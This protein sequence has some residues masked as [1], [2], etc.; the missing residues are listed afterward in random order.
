MRGQNHDIAST[1]LSVRSVWLASVLWKLHFSVPVYSSCAH[2][3]VGSILSGVQIVTGHYEITREHPGRP[4]PTC[5]QRRWTGAHLRCA[6]IDLTDCWLSALSLLASYQDTTRQLTTAMGSGPVDGKYAL[7]P[8]ALF[9]TAIVAGDFAYLSGVPGSLNA[10]LEDQ[11][12][13]G[14]VSYTLLRVAQSLST[15]LT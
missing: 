4:G 8:A 5:R 12:I 9:S 14:T 6:Q 13:L 11:V 10:T 3:T 1:L 15:P 2:D 7:E